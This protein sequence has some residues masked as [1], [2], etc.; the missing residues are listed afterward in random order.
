VCI[1]PFAINVVILGGN[2]VSDTHGARFVD[3]RWDGKV[4]G[5]GLSTHAVSEMVFTRPCGR[6]ADWGGGRWDGD[7]V[8]I[9][10]FPFGTVSLETARF[11]GNDTDCTRLDGR[12]AIG[13][14]DEELGASQIGSAFFVGVDFFNAETVELANACVSDAPLRVDV[15]HGTFFA[16]GGVTEVLAESKGGSTGGWTAHGTTGGRV[17]DSGVGAN[18]A[19]CSKIAFEEILA[20]SNWLTVL[21]KKCIVLGARLYLRSI[22][23]SAK[24]LNIGHKGVAGREFGVDLGFDGSGGSG[25]ILGNKLHH[26]RVFGVQTACS[27]FSNAEQF[28]VGD[29][30]VVAVTSVSDHAVVP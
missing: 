19:W 3:V 25:I 10:L 17:R 6:S 12:V 16:G 13:W 18:W 5:V 4:V 2:V 27:V 11:G 7:V 26:L 15:W 14:F 9:G 28:S 24:F 23:G 8:C 22:G 21:V 1:D 29:E 20:V 30:T